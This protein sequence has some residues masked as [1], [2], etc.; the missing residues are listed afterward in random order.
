MLQKIVFLWLILFA[1]SQSV[2]SNDQVLS[3]IETNKLILLKK[4]RWLHSL[5]HSTTTPQRQKRQISHESISFF[6][7]SCPL[8]CSC[9]YDSISCNELIDACPEC[10]HWSSIDFNHINVMK[11]YTFKNFR[12]APDRRTHVIIYKLIDS[13]LTADIFKVK[14]TYCN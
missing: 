1:L 5:L 11:P 12:F 9:N 6:K 13:T 2:K 3:S 7:R 14:A 8:K 10:F 4:D